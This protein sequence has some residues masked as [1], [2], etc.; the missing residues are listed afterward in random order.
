M[1]VI[2]LCKKEIKVYTFFILLCE[3]VGG[4][5]SLI[6]MLIGG[7]NAMSLVGVQQSE[8]TPPGFIFPIVWVIL[9]ALMG[10][11]AARIWL[12]DESK[13]RTQGI[14]VFSVQLAVNFLWSII[15]FGFQWFQLAFWW[16]LLLWV[17]IIL[18][19]YIYKKL[20]KP[21]A[22]IQIPYLLWVTFATYLTYMVWMMN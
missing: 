6:A 20:D 21:A 15:F 10:I 3:L 2:F 9:Y 8:L 17:L 16:I 4:L 19:I 18:M 22:W 11:G 5:S 7:W 1:G 14:R 13:E 12:A